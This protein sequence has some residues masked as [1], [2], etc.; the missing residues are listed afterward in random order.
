M[1]TKLRHSTFPETTATFGEKPGARTTTK[2][3]SDPSRVPR[4]ALLAALLLLLAFLARLGAI[5]RLVTPDEL[6]WVYR[7]IRFRE[8][9]LAG[10]WADTLVTGHPGV[11][12]TWLGALGISVQLLVE[13]AARATYQ[14]LTHLA[15]MSPDLIP[16]FPKLA[17]FLTAGR[18][19][20]ALTTSVGIWGIAQLAQP[21]F[22]RRAAW[23]A[24]F[25]LALDPFAAGLSGL[26]H[27][28]GLSATF[29]TLSLLALLRPTPTNA[30]AN[31]KQKGLDLAAGALAALAVWTKS[32]LLLLLPFSAVILVVH[33]WGGRSWRDRW[34]LFLPRAARWGLG[35]VVTSLILLPAL[36]VGPLN[37]LQTVLGTASF[38]A[39]EA[40]RPTFFMGQVRL[41]PSPWLYPVA[42]L[43]RLSPLVL[44]GLALAGLWQLQKRPRW[45][46]PA[47]GWLLAWGLLFL[48]AISLAPKKF[49]RYTLP[50]IFCLALVAAA[51]WA[52]LRERLALHCAAKSGQVCQLLPRIDLAALTLQA[53]LLAVVWPFTLTAYNPLLGGG[54]SA[55][56]VLD[57]GWGEGTSIA[58]RWLAEQPEASTA[59]AV[60][61]NPLALSTFFPGAVL[62]FDKLNLPRA[63][64]LVL[65]VAS[66]QLDPAEFAALTA[67]A[68]LIHT[69]RINGVE[70]AWVYRNPNPEA[71]SPPLENLPQPFSFANR[72][73]LLGAAAKA[74]N[75]T[76]WV[77]VRWGLLQ[78]GGRY[79]VQARL[80][81]GWGHEWLT[82][83][84][85]LLND[86]F[87]YPEHWAAGETPV[88]QYQLNLP[89][90]IP[91][92]DYQIELSL[93]DATSG[94]RL[95]LLDDA[96][97]FSGVAYVVQPVAVPAPETPLLLAGLELPAI[98]NAGWDDGAL[99][100]LGFNPPADKLSS[101]DPVSFD[102][103]WLPKQS[104]PAGLSLE[105]SLG[106]T[107]QMIQPLSRTPSE[108]WQPDTLIH[109]KYSFQA[110]PETKAGEYELRI[111]PLD[112]DDRPLTGEPVSLGVINVKSSDRLFELPADVDVPLDYRLGADLRLRGIILE[113]PAVRPGETVHLTLVWQVETPPEEIVTAFVHLVASDDSIPAQADRWPGLTLSTSWAAGQV[114]VDSYAIP[115]PADAPT[116]AYRVATGLYRATDG[117]RLAVTGPDGAA[118]A[119]GRIFAPVTLEVYD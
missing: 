55:L 9:L 101:G 102:L 32:P 94:E 22:G 11:T 58:A 26:L 68:T 75:R 43:F 111:R 41:D 14:W 6:T 50:V 45:R 48:T 63:D 74:S 106:D 18:L 88:V 104:L 29:A 90:G 76:I 46:C 112:A 114:I 42:L 93:F 39:E 3:Q 37:V 54:R 97:D 79:T 81:D 91:P 69:V 95:A 65:D 115:L 35:L 67:D 23:L 77:R 33:A 98:S 99:I 72:V 2:P 89:A 78:E 119:D 31:K 30:G 28:D 59:S 103:F 1:A 105:I 21:L 82:Q 116:G 15:W 20:V 84:S 80:R 118:V 86:V 100:L 96:G 34:R 25:F 110:P 44:V 13:P 85:P 10:H 16:A 53:V 56:Q 19:A 49:D 92:A 38:E 60:A 57:A 108:E 113:T 12:T 70:H 24:A 117:T 47:A 40:L 8:A 109:E 66:R 61:G 17:S 71:P 51:G 62:P 4:D 87:F 5:E 36:W 52:E 73:Q 7:S 83:E 64:Y 27:V 107:V